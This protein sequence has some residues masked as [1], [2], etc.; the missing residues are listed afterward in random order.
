VLD[1][2]NEVLAE[3]RKNMYPDPRPSSGLAGQFLLYI[4]TQQGNPERVLRVD[5]PKSANGDYIHFPQTADLAGFDR[6]DK[7]WVALARAYQQETGRT[8][9]IVNASDSDWQA[10]QAALKA[11]GVEVTLLC[12]SQKTK[13]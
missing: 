12:E 13:P 11:L 3:Y 2:Q 6:S 4:L 1:Q 9:P 10:A 8:A 7:K 5:S